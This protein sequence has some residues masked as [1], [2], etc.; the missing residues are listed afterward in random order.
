MKNRFLKIVSLATATGILFSLSA[1]KSNPDSI[2]TT[3][4]ASYEKYTTSETVTIV[5]VPT[6][7]AELVEMLNAALNYVDKFC[8]SYTKSVKCDADVASL[9]NLSSVSNAKDA[10]ASIFG[11]KNITYD[12]E[13][14]TD[15]TV[16]ADNFVKGPF[17][18]DEI[19]EISA[20][21]ENNLIVLTVKLID[22]D[23]PTDDDGLLC[24]LGGDYVNVAAVNKSLAEFESSANNVKISANEISIVAKISTEDSS[25]KEMTVK[26]TENFNLSG[27]TL[28]KIAGSSVVGTAK[29]TVKYTNLG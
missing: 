3:S 11:E 4:P 6:E 18:D 29:T 22:E 27:V 19:S 1:C 26:Y 10:F 8:Y 17:S 9:G 24:R 23:N 2:T 7:R 21:R 16:F 14:N 12:Y 20:K 13:Y 25:L 28:V 5:S 15:K